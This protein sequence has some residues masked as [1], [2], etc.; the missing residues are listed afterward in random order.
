MLSVDTVLASGVSPTR[1]LPV[2]R[3]DCAF[4]GAEEVSREKSSM[5]SLIQRLNEITARLIA[6]EK[7]LQQDGET[8]LECHG[9]LDGLETLV[10]GAFLHADA[11][12]DRTPH[13]A[14]G[15]RDGGDAAT[16]AS[17]D[18]NSDN[19]DSR[20]DSDRPQSPSRPRSPE[21]RQTCRGGTLPVQQQQELVRRI[22]RAAHE[23]R[24]RHEE[25]KVR[26]LISQLKPNVR[27]L[28]RKQHVHDLAIIQAGRAAQRILSLEAEV[29]EL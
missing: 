10:F 19:D 5:E 7:V 18:R 27:R 8:L 20:E 17:P 15:N 13:R 28:T 24:N 14:C 12:R 6:E 26:A 29:R 16:I 22:A 21:Q 23:L 25:L 3:F 9:K 4:F 2:H 1:P 11:P